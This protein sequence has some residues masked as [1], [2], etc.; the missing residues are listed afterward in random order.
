[1]KQNNK[2]MLCITLTLLWTTI[3]FSFSLQPGDASSDMSQGFGR[4]LL[5]TFLP[6]LLEYIKNLSMEEMEQMHFLLRKGAHFTEYFALG[7]LA[8]ITTLFM[9]KAKLVHRGLAAFGYCVLAASVDEAIQLFVPGR[10]GRVADVCLD[11]FGAVMGICFLFFIV[12]L[13]VV[14]GGTV[15]IAKQ[16]K[17]KNYIE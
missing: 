10:A 7:V 11:S 8:G 9:L 15:T 6:G 4:W 2:I 14:F 17:S 16:N 3:I 12:H 1:M 13:L 5:E